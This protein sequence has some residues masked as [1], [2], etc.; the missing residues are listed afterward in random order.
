MNIVGIKQGE[1]PQI[2]GTKN[3]FNIIIE[4]NFSNLKKICPSRYKKHTEHQI[5]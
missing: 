5:Y 3:I 1:Q 2:K 4:Y